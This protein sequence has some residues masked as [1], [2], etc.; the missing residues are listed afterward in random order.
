MADPT[1]P[2]PQKIDPTQVKIFWP[3]PITTNDTVLG[4]EFDLSM[5]FGFLE[6]EFHCECF[7]F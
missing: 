6:R 1:Q 2:K 5:F 4:W 7:M 3:G